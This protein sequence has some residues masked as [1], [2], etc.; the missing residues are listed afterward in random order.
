MNN[1]FFISEKKNFDPSNLNENEKLKIVSFK[2][3]V[4]DKYYNDPNFEIKLNND[5][6]TVRSKNQGWELQIDVHGNAGYVNTWLYKI[7]S[8][9]DHEQHHFASHNIY[10]RELSPTAHNRWVKGMP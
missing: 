5:V 8:I 9:L 1:D 3:E 2:R 10:A 4:L 7:G 6:G